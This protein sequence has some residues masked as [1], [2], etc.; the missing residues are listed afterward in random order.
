MKYHLVLFDKQ[1]LERQE[2][3]ETKMSD[4]LSR[5]LAETEPRF[6]DVFILSHGWQGDVLG[7]SEQYTDWIQ[8]MAEMKLD[9]EMAAKQ[10]EGFRPLMSS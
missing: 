9:R 5:Y 2:A 10:I 1:G 6:T 4:Q 7:A 3:N 8:V